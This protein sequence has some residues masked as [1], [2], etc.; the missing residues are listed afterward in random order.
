MLARAA[1][2][3]IDTDDLKL[4]V[5]ASGAWLYQVPRAGDGSR[6]VT[7]SNQ[8]EFQLTLAPSAITT[9]SVPARGAHLGGVEAAL[10]WSR[11]FIQSEAYALTIDGTGPG[12]SQTTAGSLHRGGLSVRR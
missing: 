12:G 6:T 4:H 10:N 7:L 3:V 8:P 5:G 9:G 2:L 1:G 11:I